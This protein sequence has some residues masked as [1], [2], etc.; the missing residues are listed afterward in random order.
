MRAT[1]RIGFAVVLALLAA[2]ALS[3]FSAPVVAQVPGAQTI[4][5]QEVRISATFA[6]SATGP[7]MAVPADQRESAYQRLLALRE[8]QAADAFANVSPS[9]AP[10]SAEVVPATE[11]GDPTAL[12]ASAPGNFLIG[13]DNRNPRANNPFMGS[14]LAEPSA[15]NFADAVIAAGNFNHAEFSSD[16]GATWTDISPDN[17]G[18]P[19][20]VFT[21]FSCCDQDNIIDQ[22]QRLF[23]LPEF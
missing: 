6:G 8:Q 13:R 2:V 20:P 18:E 16:G 19:P 4:A 23:Q 22:Q 1:N 7:V 17:L 11:I 3:R 5:T 12:D 14:S 9:G 10:A 21:D 15:A